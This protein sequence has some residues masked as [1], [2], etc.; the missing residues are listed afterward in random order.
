MGL[1]SSA[2]LRDSACKVSSQQGNATSTSVPDEWLSLASQETVGLHPG[3]NASPFPSFP[4]QRGR[5]REQEKEEVWD[6]LPSKVGMEQKPS[7]YKATQLQGQSRPGACL[8][9]DWA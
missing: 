2:L 5:K 3:T 9:G 1:V 8:P 4:G 6:W 7:L